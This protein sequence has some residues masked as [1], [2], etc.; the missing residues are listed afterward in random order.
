MNEP[1]T[2]REEERFLETAGE[3]KRKRQE[4][5][6]LTEKGKKKNEIKKMSTTILEIS[7]QNL[8]TL[9]HSLLLNH[10]QSSTASKKTSLRV[11]G[12]LGSKTSSLLL[13]CEE[14]EVKQEVEEGDLPSK[15]FLSLLYLL[16]F[17]FPPWNQVLSKPLPK[18]VA[19]TP[20]LTQARVKSSLDEVARIPASFVV[21]FSRTAPT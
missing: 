10:P 17:N 21:K 4:R 19:L 16:D 6:V 9:D 11:F 12:C 8:R 20:S 7:S 1:F 5:K 14:E 13:Q 2:I 15:T 18:K 3:D